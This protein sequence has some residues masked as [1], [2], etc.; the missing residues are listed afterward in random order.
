MRVIVDNTKE[1]HDDGSQVL[2]SE[3]E[4]F[5]TTSFL[6]FVSSPHPSAYLDKIFYKAIQTT[7]S[8]TYNIF[9]KK[10]LGCFLIIQT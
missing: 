1:G 4:F 2:L 3:A 9:F 6:C 5:N 7:H 8:W 10:T